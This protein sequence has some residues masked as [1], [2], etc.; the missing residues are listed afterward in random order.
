MATKSYT[1]SQA[2]AKG[3][4][5]FNRIMCTT[6]TEGSETKTLRSVIFWNHEDKED[7]VFFCDA[8]QHLTGKDLIGHLD[9]YKILVF[10][11]GHT[12][13]VENY[14]VEL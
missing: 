8:L 11:D 9:D 5:K 10:E 13:I 3:S 14:E 12:T 1:L 6:T 4:I 2:K 7:T